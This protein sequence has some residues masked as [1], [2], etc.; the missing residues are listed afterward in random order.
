MLT[1]LLD[2]NKL[3]LSLDTTVRITWYNPVCFFD[4][5]P[6][7]T[8]M[9]IE[10][11][12]NEVNRTWF[13]NPQRFEKMQNDADREFP[14]FEIRYGGFLLLAG[15]LIVQT[16]N[17]ESYKCWLRNNVGDLGKLHREKYIYDIDEFNQDVDFENKANYVPGTDH[18]GCPEIF[19]PEFFYDKG[20]KITLTR[21]INNPDYVDLSWW[22]DLF[23][24]QKPAFIDEPYETEALT[25][26]FRVTASW[27]INKLNEDSTLMATADSSAVDLLYINLKVFVVSPMLFLRYIIEAIL[28]DAKFYINQ[29]IIKDNP[30]FN[31]LML[32]SNYDITNIILQKDFAS[33][34][35][36]FNWN[37]NKTTYARL[38]PIDT[39]SRDYSTPFQYKNLLPKI[40]LADFFLSI[41][42]ELNV[43]FHFKTDNKV[44]ILDREEILRNPSI[45]VDQFRINEMEM[46]EKKYVTLKFSFD[47]DSNDTFFSERWEDV[48]DRRADQTDSVQNL[49]DLDAITDPKLGEIRYIINDNV[50]FEYAWIQE[51]EIDGVTGKEIQTDS[52][53]WK[54]LAIGFQNGYHKFG[55]D[56]VED[57]NSKFST[58]Y[59]DQTVFTYQ[60]GNV[61]SLKFAYQNFT[62]RLLFY[63][64]NNKASFETETLSL[65]WEKI[66]TGLLEK[67]YKTWNPFWSERQPVSMDMNFP[68][69]AIAHTV[70]NITSK[71]RTNK[72]EFL[73][74]SMETTFGLN[75]IGVSHLK[76]FKY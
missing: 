20:R 26:A 50:Y 69:N 28:K 51:V 40:K 32:F 34:W 68:L 44:N 56:E 29:N 8:G 19:N 39:I 25:E 13:G 42:N 59:G 58:L 18:Y 41:Q 73:I 23:K 3:A 46:G 30:D 33:P 31:K 72:G 1:Y 35:Q 62:P 21:K 16:A 48:E 17:N 52:L 54:H 14:N 24:E 63:H 67:R 64:G 74:E 47:H 5:I 9:G 11:P 65:D 55:R 15:T 38:R 4:S 7:D 70:D 45:D 57:I 61:K 71:F 36:D 12:F 27:F 43:V 76:T 10:I 2:N 37:D 6:G 60:R 49:I 66:N 22:Q 53:G 75:S